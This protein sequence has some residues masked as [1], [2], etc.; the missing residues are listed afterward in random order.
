[1]KEIYYKLMWVATLATCLA[2]AGCGGSDPKPTQ[3]EKVT[4]MLTSGGGTWAPRNNAGITVDGIDVTNELFEGFSITFGKGTYSTTG[5]TPVF[6]RE[7]TWRFKDGQAKVIIRGSDN[8]EMTLVEISDT[9][10][11][12]T[13]FWDETTTSGGRTGALRGN[14]EFILSK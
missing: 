7:D 14:H 8:K 2:L 10:M 12:L 3:E 13:L 9:Q 1:M 5:T 11:K 4:K 6:P